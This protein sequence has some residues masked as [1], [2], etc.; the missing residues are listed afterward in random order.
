MSNSINS[1]CSYMVAFLFQGNLIIMVTYKR[2]YMSVCNSTAT[3]V[4]ILTLGASVV[5]GCLGGG[6]NPFPSAAA[7]SIC[8][9]RTLAF[10]SSSADCNDDH[11][12]HGNAYIK[13]YNIIINFYTW[14]LSSY[15]RLCS[16]CTSVTKSKAVSDTRCFLL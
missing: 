12:N 3:T 10:L 6:P 1:T 15:S 16:D 2:K 5:E 7:F 9:L 11:C 8:N 14:P 13:K 4:C